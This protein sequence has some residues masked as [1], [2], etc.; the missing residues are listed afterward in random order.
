MASVPRT[1]L[2]CAERHAFGK[3]RGFFLYVRDVP[4]RPRHLLGDGT[5]HITARG[6]AASEIFLD[7]HDYRAFLVLFR[8]A[9][10]RFAWRTRAFCLMPNHYHLV[11]STPRIELSA[12]MHRLNCLYA[13]RFNNR[14]ERPGHLFQNRFDARVVE[15]DRHIRNVCRYVVNNPVRAGLVKRREDWPWWGLGAL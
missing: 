4:R 5:F 15:G 10:N 14:N 12:G 1:L 11:V 9:V 6:V 13:M 2:I 3:S 7:D 8:D